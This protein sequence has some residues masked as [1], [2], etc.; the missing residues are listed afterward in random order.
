MCGN[1]LLIADVLQIYDNLHD[2][3]DSFVGYNGL[4]TVGSCLCVDGFLFVCC[5]AHDLSYARCKLLGGD[6]VPIKTSSF[7]CSQDTIS[8]IDI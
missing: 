4:V 1:P 8:M 7:Y 3:D 5:C 2:T 6:V